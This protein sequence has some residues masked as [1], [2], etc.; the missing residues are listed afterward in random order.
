MDRTDLKV[1]GK[2]VFQAGTAVST[3]L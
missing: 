2:T 1:E 3:T